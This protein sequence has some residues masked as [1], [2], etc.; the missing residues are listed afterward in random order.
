MKDLNWNGILR[1]NDPYQR[2]TRLSFELLRMAWPSMRLWSEQETSPGL[3]TGVPWLTVR[4]REH[5]ACGV[6]TGR[7]MIGKSIDRA[8]GYEA[9]THRWRGT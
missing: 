6:V 5:I 3:M 2:L 1:P 8:D 7:R 9:Y 4:S